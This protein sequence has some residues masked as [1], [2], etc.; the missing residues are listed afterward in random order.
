MRVWREF[1]TAVSMDTL[2][3]PH[4]LLVVKQVACTLL[5]RYLDY[6]HFSVHYAMYNSGH[7]TELKD[8]IG[9]YC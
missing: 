1:A 7:V 9:H 2:P 6:A 5:E 4:A 8:L 3:L